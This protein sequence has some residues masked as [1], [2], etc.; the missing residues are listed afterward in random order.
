MI[1]LLW[2]D[3]LLWLSLPTALNIARLFDPGGTRVFAFLVLVLIFLN[4][5]V[6][7]PALSV[8][9]SKHLYKEAV[10]QHTHMAPIVAVT[11]LTIVLII[12]YVR[13]LG[14]YYSISNVIA[15][16]GIQMLVPLAFVMSMVNAQTQK[17]RHLLIHSIILSLPL[18]VLFNVIAYAAGFG[19]SES[20]DM[21]MAEERGNQLL[22]LVGITM[23]RVS[24]PLTF[25]TNIFGA[26][27]ALSTLICVCYILYT[28]SFLRW[29]CVFLLPIN[30]GALIL[31]DARGATAATVICGLMA[32]WAI[33]HHRRIWVLYPAVLLT[34]VFPHITYRLFDVANHSTTFSFLV[35]SG[36]QGSRLGVG[37]GR[38]EIWEYIAKYY[39]D[40]EWIHLIGYGAFGH[41]SSHLSAG[42]SWI[43]NS[44]GTTI[45]GCHNAFFQYLIDGGYIGALIWVA[46]LFVFV[47]EGDRLIK[48]DTAP[49][50]FKAIIV[51][52]AFLLVLQSQTETFGT[53]YT[54]EILD[55]MVMA[56]L[57]IGFLTKADEHS[58]GPSSSAQKR[59]TFRWGLPS[60]PRMTLNA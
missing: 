24:F 29:A 58:A 56:L 31:T 10:R 17:E 14:F 5:A 12:C 6:L 48:A 60:A 54:T 7:K 34:P 3:A 21:A 1:N 36:S 59:K 25:G 23:A 42:Y 19:G 11:V 43:F 52:F 4:N 44:I 51:S 30:I 22:G 38:G 46:F 40:F 16:A 49:K 57:A 9:H 47:W 45:M 33:R 20:L 55:F 32:L 39:S 18:H 13:A 8:K 35:R 28:R 2:I 15:N 53:L 50:A 37:T 41:A 27:S 26:V